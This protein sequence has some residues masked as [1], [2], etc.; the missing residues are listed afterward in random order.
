M[1]TNEQDAEVKKEYYSAAMPTFPVQDN[2]G[3]TLINFGMSKIE[4]AA[5]I[6]AAGWW[7]NPDLRRDTIAAEAVNMAAEILRECDDRQKLLLKPVSKIL[8]LN[9]NK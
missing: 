8:D 3:Q 5:I 6:L 9:A 7:N 1:N 2:Y 4:Y